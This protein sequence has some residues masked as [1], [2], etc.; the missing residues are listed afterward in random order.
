[1]LDRHEVDTPWERR[2]LPACPDSLVFD[3]A[4]EIGEIVAEN[5]S[6][7]PPMA[8]PNG[9]SNPGGIPPESRPYSTVTFVPVAVGSNQ[10]AVSIRT[11]AL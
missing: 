2:C 7:C 10:N 8:H 9:S 3:G 4:L 5:L 1:M 6:T 11:P